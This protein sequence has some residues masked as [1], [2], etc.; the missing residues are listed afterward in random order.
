M[1]ENVANIVNVQG[2]L[3][4]QALEKIEKDG[5]QVIYGSITVLTGGETET[6]EVSVY[7][8]SKY[9]NG[10]DNPNYATAE[11][12]MGLNTVESVGVARADSVRLTGSFSENRYFREENGD[13][14]LTTF[15]QIRGNFLHVDSA[16]KASASFKV[17]GL[18]RSFEE[19]TSTTGESF[20]YSLVLDV[21][22]TYYKMF[23]PVKLTVKDPIAIKYISGAYMPGTSYVTVNGNIVS[24]TVVREEEPTELG[25]GEETV[26]RSFSRRDFMVVGG[27]VPR[28]INMTEDEMADAVKTR[29]E[30]IA[31]A[32]AKRAEKLSTSGSATG[33]GGPAATK[34]ATAGAAKPKATP[35]FDF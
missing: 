29:T 10:K 4:G 27:S 20:G 30:V 8:A 11:R 23:S 5:K 31:Q 19:I 17:D 9:N 21:Y 32:K 3:Y 26:K 2:K 6:V 18:V 14:K 35:D 15:T 1:I 25:F 7:A 22:D 13:L 24:S 33:F 34:P 28:E 12:I 16:A